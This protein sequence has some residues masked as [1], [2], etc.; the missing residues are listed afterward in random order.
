MNDQWYYQPQTIG[1]PETIGPL[2]FNQMVDHVLR[3]KLKKK[4]LVHSPTATGN[5]WIYANQTP[6]IE[7][8]VKKAKEA[9]KESQKPT[10]PQVK[11]ERPSPPDPKTRS[12]EDGWYVF[13][14]ENQHG[15][16]SDSDFKIQIEKGWI[17]SRCHV[18]H[19]RQTGGQWQRSFGRKTLL[20]M[21]P[22]ELQEKKTCPYCAELILKHSIKCKHCGEFLAKS[23]RVGSPVQSSSGDFSRKPIGA[24]GVMIG[25]LVTLSAFGMKTTVSTGSGNAVHNI[26]LQQQQM[27]L[28]VIGVAIGVI[29][30]YLFTKD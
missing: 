28:L 9:R 20:A 7:A 26:G 29:G 3:R 24:I 8:A 10:T 5:Q 13:D 4:D 2:T 11:P 27:M 18:L 30:I 12:F 15:P 17:H 22:Y 19:L 25:I 1:T 21:L 6:I 16:V 23:S 14:G